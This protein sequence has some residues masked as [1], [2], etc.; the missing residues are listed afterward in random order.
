MI[1]NKLYFAF[2]LT[3][4]I[5]TNSFAYNGFATDSIVYTRS[6]ISSM[7]VLNT[8]DLIK[9][10]PFHNYFTVDG[11]GTYAVPDNPS[12]SSR[13]IDIFINDHKIDI[14]ILNTTALNTFPVNIAAF[15]TVIFYRPNSFVNNHLCTNGAVKFISSLNKNTVLGGFIIGNE[16][17][18]PGPYLYVKGK[19]SRNV[20]KI[21][22]DGYFTAFGKYKE[23]GGCLSIQRNQRFYTDEHIYKRHQNNYLD[24]EYNKIKKSVYTSLNSS[25]KN[26]NLFLSMSSNE[27]NIFINTTG[28]E[29]PAF[30]SAFNSNYFLDL[31][32]F[33][34]SFSSNITDIK[35]FG[36]TDLDHFDFSQNIN[37]LSL[38]CG[39][40]KHHFTY[41]LLNKNFMTNDFIKYFFFHNPVYSFRNNNLNLHFDA[42][43]FL[44]HLLSYNVFAEFIKK[45]CDSYSLSASGLL[46]R[47]NFMNSYEFLYFI[48]DSSYIFSNNITLVDQLDSDK[49]YKSRLCLTFAYNSLHFGYHLFSNNNFYKDI[50]YPRQYFTIDSTDY[51][52]YSPVFLENIDFG[53]TSSLDFQFYLNF[54]RVRWENYFEYFIIK[55]GSFYFEDLFKKNSSYTIKSSFFYD[56]NNRMFLNLNFSLLGKRH[57]FDYDSLQQSVNREI[58]PVTIFDLNLTKFFFKDHLKIIM[59]FQNILDKHIITHPIG[60]GKDFTLFT[61]AEFRF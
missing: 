50:I 59:S 43:F 30:S 7:G 26:H 24:N 55:K 61:K 56:M 42:A 8:D 47:K 16:I 34:V 53:F 5:F 60:A 52:F 3:F 27:K 54:K 41:I 32:L 37:Q 17:N 31:N 4:V 57:F 46:S 9:R 2:L 58:K 12:E 14:S 48:R 40:N 13:N 35:N 49:F 6:D 23:L 22:I 39:S 25:W 51:R 15:D 45:F 18:D 19:E 11:Y 20:D 10:N 29:I 28:N 36:R 44:D 1:K 21:G 38:I 33:K